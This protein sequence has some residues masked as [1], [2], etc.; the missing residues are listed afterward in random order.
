M[1]RTMPTEAEEH[2][3]REI[4]DV[5]AGG[6]IRGVPDEDIVA[7]RGTDQMPTITIGAGVEFSFVRHDGHDPA[8][9]KAA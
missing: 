9:W 6:F 7:A 2:G 4:D 8:H 5:A 1:L 3:D